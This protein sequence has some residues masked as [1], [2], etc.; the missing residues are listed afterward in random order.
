MNR[1]SN[2]CDDD[3]DYHRP[4][5]EDEHWHIPANE[6]VPFVENNGDQFDMADRGIG[7]LKGQLGIP[8]GVIQSSEDGPEATF[9]GDEGSTVGELGMGRVVNGMDAQTESRLFADL[10]AAYGTAWQDKLDAVL[11]VILA[12][13]GIAGAAY[14]QQPWWL[15]V[16]ITAQLSYTL[17][18]K[19]T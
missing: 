14:F 2:D 1:S 18:R 17:A 16:A 19:V 4:Y 12:A 3:D 8:E 6:W 10:Y 9:E 15:G 11:V 7:F 13:A 5:W